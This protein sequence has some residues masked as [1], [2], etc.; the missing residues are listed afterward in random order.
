MSELMVWVSTLAICTLRPLGVM[1]L[2]PL[3]SQKSLGGI[4]IRNALVIMIAMPVLPV[5]KELPILANPQMM[6]FVELML[7]ELFIGLCIGF[8]A[9]IPFWAIDIAGFVIDTMRGASMST[10]YN[11][12]LGTQASVFGI[13]FSQ[14]LTVLFLVT[15][16]FNK[17]LNGIYASYNSLPMGQDI[18]FSKGFL[19]FLSHEWHLMFDLAISFALPAMVIMLMVDLALG[20]INRSAQQLNVFF[21]SMPIKSAMA[22]LLI[23]LSLNFSF[24]HYLQRMNLF[25]HQVQNL[26]VQMRGGDDG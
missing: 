16:G 26:I 2:L 24:G 13:L 23:L 22:I 17:L 3:F 20:L 5:Y 9:A 19:V 15:G 1:L 12:L 7:R 6:P 14:V 10:V 8:S 21:L 4:L 18:V 25:E 11:P